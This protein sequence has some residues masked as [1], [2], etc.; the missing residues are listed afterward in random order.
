MYGRPSDTNPFNTNPFDTNPFSTNNTIQFNTDSETYTLTDYPDDVID[1]RLRQTTTI[2]KISNVTYRFVVNGVAMSLVMAS[3]FIPPIPQ[4]Y[5]EIM[6][7]GL[8]LTN[9]NAADALRALTE[10]KHPFS[11]LTCFTPAKYALAL[12]PPMGSC[13]MVGFLMQKYGGADTPDNILNATGIGNDATGMGEQ[14]ISVLLHNPLAHMSVLAGVVYS[15]FGLTKYLLEC[16]RKPVE[17]NEESMQNWLQVMIKTGIDVIEPIALYETLR[18]VLLQA[19]QEAVLHNQFFPLLVIGFDQL[20]KCWGYMSRI[21]KPLDNLVPE[22][23]VLVL[24]ERNID[25]QLDEMI[26][27][28]GNFIP[29]TSCRNIAKAC[30][31]Y[32]MRAGFAVTLGGMV[33]WET[34]NLLRAKT[35]QEQQE[36]QDR[37]LNLLIIASATG[38]VEKAVDVTYAAGSFVWSKLSNCRQTLFGSSRKNEYDEF[39]ENEHEDDIE[40]LLKQ[41]PQY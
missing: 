36:S 2:Q 6:K 19:G 1:I 3:E 40:R 20:L 29:R 33:A 24:D 26:N 16:C 27:T 25:T 9:I 14:I 39:L 38:V 22:E 10:R 21:P 37:L 15:E 17:V 31:Y 7:G 23:K 8:I 32:V 4:P 28:G 13:V 41:S 11:G 5:K 18:I 12:I 30:G 34:T 35:D